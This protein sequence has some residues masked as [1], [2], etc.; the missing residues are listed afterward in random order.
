MIRRSAQAAVVEQLRHPAGDGRRR[1]DDRNAAPGDDALEHGRQE[2]IVRAPQHDLV[3]APGQHRF[4]GG[5]HRGFGLG[6]ILPVPFNQLHEPRARDGQ[7]LDPAAVPGGGAAEQ[8]AVEAPLGGQHPH[9]PAAG[10]QTGGFHGGLHAH[11]RQPGV[12]F[13][14]KVDGRGRGGVAG[15]DDHLATHPDQPRDGGVGQRPHLLPG[16]GAVGTVGAVAQVDE[17]FAR[18]HAPDLAP[19]G[20]PAQ[21][22]IVN[23][24]RRVI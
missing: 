11:D 7:D 10:G 18:Q 15:H 24:D 2:R 20:Q 12:F 22:R 14:Q 3:G 4:H 13:A 19:N 17:R 6:R 16:P 8:L 23:A 5:A 1:I 9:H 21:P